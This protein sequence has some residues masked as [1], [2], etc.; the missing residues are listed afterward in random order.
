[1]KKIGNHFRIV[2]SRERERDPNERGIKKLGG[3]Q[4]D[5][6]KIKR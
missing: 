2:N 5:E 6:G 3:E 1:M 4:L